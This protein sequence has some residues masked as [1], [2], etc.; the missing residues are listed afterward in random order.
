ML[1]FRSENDALA[2]IM[3]GCIQVP[4]HYIWFGVH[5]AKPSDCTPTHTCGSPWSDVC[6]PIAFQHFDDMVIKVSR[7]CVRSLP[8][9]E[10]E[11]EEERICALLRFYCARHNIVCIHRPGCCLE[12]FLEPIRYCTV[13]LEIFSRFSWWQFP[14]AKRSWIF[15]RK[16]L[17]KNARENGSRK[18]LEKMARE[19]GSRN[20]SRK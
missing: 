4:F 13:F 20:D 1:L 12:V 16:W 6:C 3:D 5:S 18:W 11:A 2:S 7:A 8:K 9:A 17:E 10:R 15:S 19:N 14:R